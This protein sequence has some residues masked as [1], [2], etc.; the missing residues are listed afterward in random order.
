MLLESLLVCS[1]ELQ[2]VSSNSH[3]ICVSFLGCC[4]QE[5]IQQL[6]CVSRSACL[7]LQLKSGV[8]QVFRP[9]GNHMSCSIP[10]IAALNT[11]NAGLAGLLSPMPGKIVKI[12][13][14]AGTA[15]TKGTPIIAMEAMKMEHMISAPVDGALS[16][17]LLPTGPIPTG[18][19][20][21]TVSQYVVRTSHSIAL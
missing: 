14:P 9:C 13:V 18:Y 16:A 17:L 11:A 12:L 15:V 10:Q 1:C 19:L 6:C 2:Y 8:A 20:I 4:A 21:Q 7:R 3:H 5:Y